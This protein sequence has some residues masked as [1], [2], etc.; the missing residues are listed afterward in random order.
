M[1]QSFL[2]F[3]SPNKCI[4][5]LLYFAIYINIPLPLFLQVIFLFQNVNLLHCMTWLALADRK[6]QGVSESWPDG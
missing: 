2:L 5:T 6:D 1:S 4:F 3:Y